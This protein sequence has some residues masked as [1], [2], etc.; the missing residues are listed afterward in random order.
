MKDTFNCLI[1]SWKFLPESDRTTEIEN[2]ILV[3]SES[4]LR[5]I[6]AKYYNSPIGERAVLNSARVGCWKALKTYNAGVQVPFNFWCPKW[7][8]GEILKEI[9]KDKQFFTNETEGEIGEYAEHD[10]VNTEMV[11]KNLPDLKPDPEKK[12]MGRRFAS[13]LRRALR[14]LQSSLEEAEYGSVINELRQIADDNVPKGGSRSQRQ[15]R[16][17]RLGLVREAVWRVQDA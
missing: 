5:K 15:K 3:A 7:I 17:L 4:M 2:R 16:N 12:A 1:N 10:I 9:K 11:E 14:F 13:D 8:K 6:S